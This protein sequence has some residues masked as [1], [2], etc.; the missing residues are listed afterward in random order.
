MRQMVRLTVVGTV[1][2]LVTLAAL[3]Q[4]G[5]IQVTGQPGVRIYLD[6][7]FQGVT[8]SE[9]DGLYLSG[10]AAGEHTVRAEKR[11][12]PAQAFEIVARPG[13]PVE[14]TVQ[15]FA[16]AGNPLRVVDLSTTGFRG[17]VRNVDGEP[18]GN[19]VVQYLG[20]SVNSSVVTTERGSFE[21]LG[22]EPGPYVITVTA[23]GHR[24]AVNTLVAVVYG[25]V[26]SVDVE[27]IPKFDLGA[28]LPGDAAS[29]LFLGA[30]VV[31]GLVFLVMRRRGGNASVS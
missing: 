12:L 25:S 27:L 4:T 16:V 10:I 6:E 3:A 15:P 7:V 23:E 2:A 19:A 11:G 26:T 5:A 1:G 13:Q 30:I 31:I 20:P 18:V 21:R 17:V 14:V 9:G 24:P 8:K 29:N 22:V 28:A